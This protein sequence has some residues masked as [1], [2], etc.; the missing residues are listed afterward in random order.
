MKNSKTDLIDFD[1][2]LTEEQVMIAQSVR[3]FT[4]IEVAPLVKESFKEGVFP[5]GLVKKMGELGFLGSHID[6]YG[7]PGLDALSYGLIMY[8]LERMDSGLRSFASVQGAL[9]MWPIYKFGSDKQ[10]QDYLP[11]M[12]AGELIG[13]FGLTEADFG[14]NPS[15]MQTHAKQVKGGYLLNG[16]KMWIT[17]G[18]IADIAIIWAKLEGEIRAFIVPA[19]TDGFS[20]L[21]IKG[22]L[23][24]RMS[25]TSELVLEN[26]FI[27]KDHILEKAIGLRSALECLNQA[28]FGISWG[29]LGAADC[30]YQTALDYAQV[31]SIF[32]KPLASFQL[33]QAKLVEMCSQIA[34]A[35]ILM[36]HLSKKKDAGKLKHAQISLAKMNNC[37]V[38]LKSARLAR[39]LLGAAGIVD[40]YPIM[41]HLLNLESVNT[42]EGTEDIHRLIIGKEITGH[43]AIF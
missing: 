37:A 40:E 35:K 13:C 25:V 42:Y 5:Q 22:K 28:R 11:K 17:N 3:K 18:G 27:P 20:T 15:G 39:D 30:V 19:Q 26:C 32:S 14:S 6:G 21:P 9:C 33:A 23:S 29:V 41:R 2:N 4:H 10:K 38:A 16:S 8:E 36:L 34:L 43:N 1:E 31:R 24:L 12:G 7:L